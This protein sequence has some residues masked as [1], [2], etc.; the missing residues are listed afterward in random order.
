MDTAFHTKRNISARRVNDAKGTDWVDIA[1]MIL[2]GSPNV[3]P[4]EK[5][6]S[7]TERSPRQRKFRF[8]S[9]V[10]ERSSGP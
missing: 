4:N 2:H 5:I 1:V 8:H 7:V 10:D 9:A 3:T 6:P